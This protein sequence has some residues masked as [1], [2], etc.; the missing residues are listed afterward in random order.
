MKRSGTEIPIRTDVE[1][2]DFRWRSNPEATTSVI[3]YWGKD[4]GSQLRFR[5]RLEG[6]NLAVSVDP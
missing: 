1:F 3:D 6:D 4:F 2:R 5:Q